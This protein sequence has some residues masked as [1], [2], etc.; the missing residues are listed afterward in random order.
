MSLKYKP[1]ANSI[2]FHPLN[3][4]TPDTKPYTRNSNPRTRTQTPQNPKP[5]PQNPQ[6]QPQNLKP[7]TPN[8]EQRA[9]ARRTDQCCRLEK[10]L[11]PTPSTLNPKPE[12]VNVR[13]KP[14]CGSVLRRARIYGPWTR[15]SLNSRLESNKEIKRAP[16]CAELL[17][18]LYY[19]RA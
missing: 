11:H 15:V 3:S 17:L 9:A 19:S 1:P 7:D 13:R 12:A 5:T 16:S 2:P 18:L 14:K 8:A 4:Q 10:L 6:P